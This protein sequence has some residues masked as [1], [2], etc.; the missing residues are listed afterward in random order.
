MNTEKRKPCKEMGEFD[1]GLLDLGDVST[2]LEALGA[3]ELEERGELNLDV[4]GESAPEY[5]YDSVSSPGGSTCSGPT[6]IRHSGFGPDVGRPLSQLSAGSPPTYPGPPSPLTHS[7]SQPI[8]LTKGLASRHKL[9]NQPYLDNYSNNQDSRKKKKKG[10]LRPEFSEFGQDIRGQQISGSKLTGVKLG[11]LTS[12]RNKSRKGKSYKLTLKGEF[13][14]KKGVNII[15]RKL[16]IRK[17][18]DPAIIGRK[19]YSRKVP[20]HLLLRECTQKYKLLI[21]T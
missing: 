1:D 5:D 4:E 6:Y 9:P 15:Q 14:K 17:Y 11:T 8:I 21:K 12:T 2:D 3:K 16:T 13:A 10:L 20:D 18:T 19:F 7:L